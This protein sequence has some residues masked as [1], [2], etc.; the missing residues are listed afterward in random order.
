V[1][2]GQRLKL[3]RTRA[4]MTQAELAAAA[5]GVC[6]QSN[7]S[8]LERTD[9]QGSDFTLQFARALKIDPWWLATGEGSPDTVVSPEASLPEEEQRLL[10]AYRGLTAEQRA[11]AL[12]DLT[13]QRERNEELAQQLSTLFRK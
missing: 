6:Q 3:A 10:H 12:R 1:H 11:T 9:S 2:Y 7:V 13:G 5:G 8:K 4:G